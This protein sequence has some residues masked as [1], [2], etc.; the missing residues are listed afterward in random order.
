MS[1]ALGV[2]LRGGLGVSSGTRRAEASKIIVRMRAF[3]VNNDL[4]LIGLLRK[5]LVPT[6]IN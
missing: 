5:L 2:F 4:A 6:S 1:G 3:Q